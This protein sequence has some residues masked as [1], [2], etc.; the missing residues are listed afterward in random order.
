MASAEQ[1]NTL[2]QSQVQGDYALFFSIAMQL[3]AHE[4]KLGHGKLAKELRE[5]IDM[6][7]AQG[8]RRSKP[9]HTSGKTPRRV[10]RAA[11]CQLSQAAAWRTW[12]YRP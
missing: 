8:Q 11:C 12:S 6:A 7:K 4:A 2:L 10:V 9:T 1:L 5:L 3:A